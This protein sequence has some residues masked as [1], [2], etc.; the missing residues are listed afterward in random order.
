MVFNDLLLW[1]YSLIQGFWHFC[2]HCSLSLSVFS[3][4]MCPW[5]FI[6]PPTTQHDCQIIEIVVMRSPE[7][8]GAVCG[9][10]SVKHACSLVL[11]CSLLMLTMHSSS[12]GPLQL[13]IPHPPTLKPTPTSLF[14]LVLLCNVP[15]LCFPL[16]FIVSGPTYYGLSGDQ[17]YHGL[18]EQHSVRRCGMLA[19]IADIIVLKHISPIVCSCART[20]M[21]VVSSLL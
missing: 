15:G 12:S 18:S 21:P 5:Q 6:L 9:M 10:T 2:D 4:Y 13:P 16:Q 7:P 3:P 17:V 8:G 19:L 1:L 20:Q 11:Q 14:P